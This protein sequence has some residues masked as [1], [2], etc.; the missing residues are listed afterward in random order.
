VNLHVLLMFFTLLNNSAKQQK[1]RD[2]FGGS[3]A[4]PKLTFVRK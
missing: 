4:M 1:L 3:S 2:P